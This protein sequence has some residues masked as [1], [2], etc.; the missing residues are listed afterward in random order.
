MM[1]EESFA[2][3]CE[4]LAIAEVHDQVHRTFYSMNSYTT[5]VEQRGN[6]AQAVKELGQV[7]L[8]KFLIL[9]YVHSNLLHAQLGDRQFESI[10]KLVY[11]TEARS[12]S[13]QKA[14]VLRAMAKIAFTL[15]LQFRTVTTRLHLRLNGLPTD[16]NVLQSLD[17]CKIMETTPG[18]SGFL[19]DLCAIALAR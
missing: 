13:T 11:G 7:E 14:R 6:L 9:S 3:A 17:I 15:D 5:I 2:N 10:I 4:L 12:L 1:V 18:Y 19:H 8:M 16:L